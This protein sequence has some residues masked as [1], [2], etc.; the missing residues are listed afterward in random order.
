MSRRPA[1]LKSPSR[2]PLAFRVGII[3]H[4]PNRL[5]GDQERL[6]RIRW[7]LRAVL[8]E[9]KAAVSAFGDLPEAKELYVGSRPI[10]RA[11]SPL[12]EGTDRMFAEEAIELGY[13]LVCPMPFS[14]E[15]FENDF[16][17][18]SA[19]EPES[20]GRFRALIERARR[21]AG[22]TKLEL[23]GERSASHRA[24]A[25]AGRV[26]LNQSDLLIAVWDGGDSAGEGGTVETLREAADFHLPVLW[27]D[28]E[29]PQAWQLLVD[30]DDWTWP[31]P[32]ERCTPRG[33]HAVDLVQARGPIAAATAQVVRGRLS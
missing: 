20:R 17:P 33:T 13:E 3:G 1:R 6:D 11:I 12:A 8:E 21:G 9:V 31:E 25:A 32:G 24:Y 5:P 19:L 18:P 10:L 22:L 26:V 16:L 7:T 4:R 29:A 23:D 27:I 14:Q 30:P 15:E 28:A 2:A